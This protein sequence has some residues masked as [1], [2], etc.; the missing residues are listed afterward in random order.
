MVKSKGR[1]VAKKDSTRRLTQ[2]ERGK[3]YG[4]AEAG[5]DQYRIAKELNCYPKRVREQILFLRKV[6]AS[7]RAIAFAVNLRS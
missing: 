5:W 3:A 2:L 1:K 4:L 7:L 6:G